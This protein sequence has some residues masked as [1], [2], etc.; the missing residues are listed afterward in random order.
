MPEAKLAREA[1]IC[2]AAVALAT[3]YDCW[4]K[5]P[6]DERDGDKLRLL[7]EIIGNVKVA[8]Q[9]ALSLI[10]KALPALA[11]QAEK[12]CDCQSALKLGIWSDK[13]RIADD[14]KER[15]GLIIGKYM[16]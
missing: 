16:D 4:R 2:Y 11:A 1:E 7:E 15:L 10:G 5:R 6:D 12:P 13:R 3:D 8:T 14:V 9:N